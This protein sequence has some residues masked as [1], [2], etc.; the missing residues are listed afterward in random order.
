MK[1]KMKF[2][3]ALLACAMTISPIAAMAG[4]WCRWA[5]TGPT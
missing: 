5:Q 1:Q 3:A 2:F 4:Q